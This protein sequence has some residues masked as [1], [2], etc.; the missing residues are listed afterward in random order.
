[1]QIDFHHTVTYVSAR[2]A[3]FSQKEAQIIAY[4]AQYVDDATTGGAIFFRNGAMYSRISSA[5]KSIDTL[6]LRDDE[7]R[8]VWAPFHFLPGNDRRLDL[9]QVYA[10]RLVCRPGSEV[11]EKMLKAAFDPGVKSKPN[12][13][14]RLGISMHVYADTWAHQGFAGII[15][16]VNEVNAAKDTGNSGV[17][18]GILQQCL[19]GIVESAAP[20]LGHGKAYIFPDMPFLSWSYTNGR[21]QP[22][23]RNNTDIFCEAANAL[24]KAMQRYR[25]GT[26]T[27]IGTDDAA[28]IRRFFAGFKSADGKERHDK[29][30]RG[31]AEG[32]FSFGRE[33]VAY[34][35]DGNDSWKG[36]ALGDSRDLPKYPYFQ[37]FLASEWKYFHDALQEH[38]LTMLH[39]ILPEFDICLG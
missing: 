12:A 28:T 8:L 23:A 5:H 6:N 22:I 34:D 1:M 13:L 39:A 27:G 18:S 4:S 30:V 29:W 32:D 38:R 14:H 17:F 31:I 16:P 9:D 2:I 7:D 11:A 21:G 20:A 15:D 19:D 35:A 24:C 26:E 3:G 36:Q 37:G 33:D 10:N 25:G